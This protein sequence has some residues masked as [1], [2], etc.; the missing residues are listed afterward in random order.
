MHVADTLARALVVRVAREVRAGE[1][2]ESGPRGRDVVGVH[3]LDALAM[4]EAVVRRIH[5]AAVVQLGLVARVVHHRVQAVLVGQRE[6]EELEREGQLLAAAIRC[7]RQTALIRA[8]RAIASRVDLDPERLILAG[9]D[10]TRESRRGRHARSPARAAPASSRPHSPA[11]R[12]TRAPTPSSR[13]TA[14]SH[15]CS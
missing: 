10:R 14:S 7:H 8:G 2:P 13:V 4:G 9:A 1:P 6:I 3:Q 5:V 15:A 12:R 11:R